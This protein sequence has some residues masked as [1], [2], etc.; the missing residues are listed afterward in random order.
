MAI[1]AVNDIIGPNKLVFIL[2]VYRVY[3][4]ISNLNPFAPF[5]TDRAVVIRKAMAEII[6][7]RAKQT[8][9]KA[10]YYYNGLNT[11]LIY[12]LLLNSKVFI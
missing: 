5:I 8:V 2:L 10:L 7:L 6:K 3:L 11:T 4:R 1:K 12:N 9:N